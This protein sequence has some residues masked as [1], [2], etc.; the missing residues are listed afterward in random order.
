MFHSL[1]ESL[2]PT[3]RV[4]IS[5]DEIKSSEELTRQLR[6]QMEMDWRILKRRYDHFEDFWRLVERDRRARGDDDGDG[7]KP[8]TSA[9]GTEGSRGARLSRDRRVPHQLR[10]N[11]R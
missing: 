6:R 7:D 10:T 8:R 4:Y 11:R 9:T 3:G 2:S 5:L 1:P